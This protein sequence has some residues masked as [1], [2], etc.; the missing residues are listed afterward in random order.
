[1]KKIIFLISITITIVFSETIIFTASREPVA[2]RRGMVVS[3]NETVSQIGIEILKKGGNAVDAAVAVSYALA[4]VY[5][6]AGNLGGGG[7]MLVRMADGEVAAIDHRETA[8][9]KA[10]RNMY[11]DENG[12]VIP[13]KSVRGYL[14]SG[15]PGTVA[16]L[17]CAL[18]K[19][20]T[21]PLSTLIEPAIDLAENGFQISRAFARLLRNRESLF[22]R[23]PEAGSIFLKENGFYEPG[24]VLL[25]KDLARTLRIIA[26]EGPDA[27]H[28]GEIADLI[29]KEMAE[30][31]GIITMEDLAS[32]E[33]VI[34]KPVTGSYKGYTVYS[35]PPAS[36][37]GIALIQLLNI[38]E[39]F[40]IKKIGFNS[41]QTIHL[42]VEAEKRV[43]AD[44]GKYLGDTDFVDVP[45]KELTSK[46]Y[47]Q[48]IREL[49]NQNAATP[50]EDVEAGN[51]FPNEGEHTTHFSI[52]DK[53]G[54]AVS[55]TTTLNS[56]FGSGVVVT[57]AGFFM[58][59][60]MD[61]FSS[62]PGS[63]NI[64]GLIEG[65]ANSI[66]PGK[67]M[68]SC[69][70]PTIVTKDDKL[71]MVVGS[72]GGSTI[73]T[74]VLQVILNVIE[75]GMDIQEAVDAPRFHHQWKPDV[76][77]YEKFTLSKDVMENLKK[78]GHTLELRG[79]YG[80]A[81]AIVVDGKNKIYFGGADSRQEGKAIGY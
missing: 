30:N 27:F 49:I 26:E 74:T 39:G 57:E 25:Q 40:D 5:P 32:Y 69:M 29:V 80:D 73:I 50:S 64:Y 2:G 3:T 70:T 54:N 60:E 48:K 79:D 43:Y 10:H 33:P 42:M 68:L 59:N 77:Q 67:R 22:K 55:F 78:M 62:K 38:L 63:P 14:A 4:V 16:G 17:S 56:Y 1:M 31:G 51:P 65:E 15:V 75:H 34:R 7:F 45:V 44:R 72:P 35:M 76:I 11:L 81:H 24:D 13:E 9:G 23:F 6:Q 36:S 18:E 47:A 21:M 12:D 46:R 8:P 19:Y 71:F 61:D 58:N 53:D 66:E 20:G 41:S 28:R 52:V 37:G